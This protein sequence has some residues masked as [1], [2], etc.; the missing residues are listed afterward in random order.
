MRAVDTNLLVRLLARDDA[1]QVA[2]AEAFVA[3][4]AWVSHLVLIEAVW[5]LDSVYG[6]G[7]A[8]LASAVELLLEH[9][10]LT[11]QDAGS[12]TRAL[13]GFRS[14]PSLGFSDCLVLEVA[15]QAGHLPLGTFDRALAK[16]E[17]AERI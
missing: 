1:R 12:V 3:Q 17:G 11:I 15:R 14:R 13:E 5:V 10:D 4:G 7:P 16:L 2:A 6:L 8:G 9:R